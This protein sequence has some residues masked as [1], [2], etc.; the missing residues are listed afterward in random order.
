MK[1]YFQMKDKS[2]Q[3]GVI[4]PH[5]SLQEILKDWMGWYNDHKDLLPEE[6]A[7]RQ[8]FVSRYLNETHLLAEEEKKKKEK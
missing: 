7:T 5:L 2:W 4:V 3:V 1:H 8:E 6:Y